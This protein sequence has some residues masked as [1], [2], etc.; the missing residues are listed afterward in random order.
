MMADTNM[1]IAKKNI[2]TWV[3]HTKGVTVVNDVKQTT[4]M[5]ALIVHALRSTLLPAL[6]LADRHFFFWR[7]C[8]HEQSPREQPC[9]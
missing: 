1:S 7:M 5:H 4:L 6:L 9:E 2:L 8:I 3:H